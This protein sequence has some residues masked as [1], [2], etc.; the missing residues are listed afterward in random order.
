MADPFSVTGSAVG[1]VS[2]GLQI[3]KGLEWYVSSVKEAKDKAEQIA[4]ETE[5]LA[6]LLERL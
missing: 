1:I 4:T 3:C 5:E 6:S 2:L